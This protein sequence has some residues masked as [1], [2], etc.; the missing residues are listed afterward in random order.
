HRLDRQA[1]LAKQYHVCKVGNGFEPGRGDYSWQGASVTDINTVPAR[2]VRS[3][4]RVEIGTVRVELG[5]IG[6]GGAADFGNAGDAGLLAAGVVN[7]YPVTRRCQ[8]AQ[9]VARLVVADAIP[10]TAAAGLRGQVSNAELRW[11]GLEKPVALLSG[12]S[13][14]LSAAWLD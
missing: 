4:F 1:P 14:I 2:L 3:A 11:L 12:H 5:G 9:V 6:I 13:A 10:A 8:V 7:Q